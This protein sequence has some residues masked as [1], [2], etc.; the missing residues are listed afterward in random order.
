V[1]GF[2]RTVRVADPLVPPDFAVIVTVPALSP[3]A[4]P[5]ALTDATIFVDDDHVTLLVMS[6][7][8]PLL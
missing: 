6:L 4:N 5:P 8:E 3:V 2:Q 7:V 1:S